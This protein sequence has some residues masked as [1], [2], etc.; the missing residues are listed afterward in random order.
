MAWKIVCLQYQSINQSTSQSGESSPSRTCGLH[1]QRQTAGARWSATPR[2]QSNDLMMAWRR[3]KQTSH[4]SCPHTQSASSQQPHLT[5]L[6]LHLAP[7]PEPVTRRHALHDSSRLSWRPQWQADG[8]PS[9]SALINR[10]SLI[11]KSPPRR[12]KRALTLTDTPDHINRLARVLSQQ[13]QIA[14]RSCPRSAAALHVVNPFRTV[15]AVSDPSSLPPKTSQA[16]SGARW[17]PRPLRSRNRFLLADCN[18]ENE[19][20]LHTLFW[21]AA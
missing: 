17:L 9:A 18:E 11:T 19:A 13:M 2:S 20:R 6:Y 4:Q 14:L 7:D 1:T 12:C 3:K 8:E 10:R 15:S 5:R 16:W 21:F